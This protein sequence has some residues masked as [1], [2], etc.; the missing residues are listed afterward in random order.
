MGTALALPQQINTDQAIQ[1]QYGIIL[2]PGAQVA[3]Y[4][5]STGAQSQD[6]AF[7]ATNLVATLAAG[8]AHVRS[9][10]GDYVV[11][12]PGHAENIADATTI[13]NAI[14][15]G[16]RIIGVGSGTLRPTFTFT[17]TAASIAVSVNNVTIA[18]CLFLLDGINA[19]VNAFNITGSDFQF[20]G[21]EVEVSTAAKAPT[22]GFTVSA[23]A[24]RC[25]VTNNV[26]RGLSTSVA[27]TLFTVVGANDSFRCSDNEFSCAVTAATGHIAIAGAATNLKIFRNMMYN[28]A[29]A[30]TA[31]IS[32]A[33]AASDGHIAD[34]DMCVLN[35][36]TASAQGIVFTGAGSTIKCNENFCS[37]EPRLSG[38]LSPGPAT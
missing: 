5:R 16:T 38:L 1:T 7:T 34:N 12:L 15:A 17:T 33:N 35:N 23:A 29:A 6:T 25:V 3:A 37:D 9:G 28:T 20:F 21:N 19:V 13:S 14:Q 11:C 32:V 36:G 24:A 4:V 27:G 2:P 10:L 22:V 30:S 31:C 18:G 8:L 26:F